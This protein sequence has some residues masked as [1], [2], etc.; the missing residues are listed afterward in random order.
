MQVTL[1]QPVAVD[2]VDAEIVVVEGCA[3]GFVAPGQPPHVLHVDP[4]QP[5]KYGVQSDDLLLSIDGQQTAQLT[6]E[7]VAELLRSAKSLVFERP[8]AAEGKEEDTEPPSDEEKKEAKEAPPPD[9][10]PVQALQ[11]TRERSRS[12]RGRRHRHH[13]HE[14][15]QSGPSE[16]PRGHPPPPQHWQVERGPGWPPPGPPGQIRGPPNA[17]MGNAPPPWHVQPGPPPGGYPPPPDTW[18]GPYPGPPPQQPPPRRGR[19]ERNEAGGV[20]IVV[21]Q[22]P[23]SLNKMDVL[24][25]YFGRFGPVSSLQINQLRHEA[26]VTFG[27]M[28]D[29]EEAMRF[30]VLNDPSIGLR[31][32]RAKAGQR[33]PDDV[34]GESAGA[35]ANAPIA[36]SIPIIASGNMT[37]ESGSVLEAKRKREELQDR[38]KVL[39]S[40][41]TDQLKQVLARI[42]DPATSDRNR[43]QLQAILASIKDKINTLTPAPKEDP[44]KRRPMPMRSLPYQTT[45]DNRPRPAVLH[46]SKLPEEMRGPDGEVQ[47]RDALGDSVEWI[48]D[49]SED[50]SA[51]VV[52]F[53]DRR[54][55][56]ATLQ[57]QKV[58]GFTAKLQE[59]APPHYRRKPPVH[60]FHQQPRQMH[61]HKVFRPPRM[62]ERAPGSP[63]TEAFDSD[64]EDPEV[65]A[66]M[67]PPEPAQEAQ[68]GIEDAPAEAEDQPLAEAGEPEGSGEAAPPVDAEPAPPTQEPE[69]PDASMAAQSE[70][71]A[72]TP[73]VQ[74][75]PAEA[76]HSAVLADADLLPPLEALEPLAAAAE[77]ADPAEPAEPA[78]AEPAD[79]AESRGENCLLEALN[80]IEVGLFGKKTELEPTKPAEP[81]EP[82]PA[83]P[84]PSEPAPA[85]P[86][87]AEQPVE[88]EESSKLDV[89]E[90]ESAGQADAEEA[91][92]PAEAEAKGPKAKAKGKAKAKAKAAVKGT[93][94]AKSTAAKASTRA[95]AKG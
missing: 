35:V 16:P 9:S 76:E 80:T 95:K 32:W 91:E 66:S 87:S 61:T 74:E 15:T 36:P 27:R 45:L 18:R 25:E 46:L 41:L 84:A 39:L 30:P 3:L 57:D 48:R 1:T 68:E 86:A 94:K 14:E 60:R 47:L 63:E 90:P 37:L 28:K 4:G 81:A 55:A 49:W 31:P 75:P 88:P 17:W 29:A 65:L 24:N 70:A 26:I 58:W 73:A 89:A 7:K 52:R 69:A 13:S 92:P 71:Q 21:M 78:P 6:Q 82:A 44:A 34:P 8:G 20:S 79:P 12:R 40:S 93:A 51:C 19:L 59:E 22:V 56:E 2:E 85:E 11:A 72:E 53:R 5:A 64:I 77:P 83:E 23:P 38:R 10:Q 50:G 42:N 54:Q 62:A 43:E 67:R 33:A